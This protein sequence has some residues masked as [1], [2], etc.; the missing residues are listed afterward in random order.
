MNYTKI[1]AVSGASGAG[2]STIVRQLAERFNSPFLLFD[3]YTSKDT[4]PDN[5]KVWLES[6][7]NVDVITTP[8]FV[9][10]LQALMAKTN[11]RYIF[12]EEPFGRGRNT[13]SALV[14]YVVLLDQPLELCLARV[15]KR[16]TKQAD[17]NSLNFIANF[18]DKYQDHMRDVY[19]ATVNQVRDNSDLI[20]NEVASIK[21]ITD[22]ISQWLKTIQT[23]KTL[24]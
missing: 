20:I 9:L 5:M 11:C 19:I 16:H 24:K 8:D 4:Y 13:M 22:V 2:K 12:I 7:T 15:I 10:A 23:D 14:D 6:G 1:I 21:H 18:L 17:V 3:D